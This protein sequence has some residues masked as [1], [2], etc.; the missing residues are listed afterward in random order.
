MPPARPILVNG[1]E[2]A[3]HLDCSYNEVMSWA[4]SALIPS[5]PVGGGRLAFNLGRV[6]EA[7]RA[8]QGMPPAHRRAGLKEAPREGAAC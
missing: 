4:R 6:V 5:I 1:R 2:L 8:N 7:L 3:E